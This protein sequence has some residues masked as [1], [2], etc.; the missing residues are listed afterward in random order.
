MVRSVALPHRLSL[1]HRSSLYS[2]LTGF[3]RISYV[4]LT[5][6]GDWDHRSHE[7]LRAAMPLTTRRSTWDWE[8]LGDNQTHA[9]K[10]FYVRCILSMLHYM[11]WL[12]RFWIFTYCKAILQQHS[13]TM[14]T[15]TALLLPPQQRFFFLSIYQ[16]DLLCLWAG[17]LKCRR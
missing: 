10:W 6:A 17:L 8:G 5:E 12:L 15:R 14:F 9:F 4:M 1:P 3:W 7:I 16:F 11:W 13:N 2:N